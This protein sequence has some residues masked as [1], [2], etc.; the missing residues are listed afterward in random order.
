VEVDA[1]IEEMEKRLQKK[2]ELK[3]QTSGASAAAAES[4]SHPADENRSIRTS[5]KS[6]S[7]SSIKTSDKS[8]QTSF[9]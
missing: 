5:D 8:T 3:L 2:R 6:T 1:F 7:A 4:T 9:D